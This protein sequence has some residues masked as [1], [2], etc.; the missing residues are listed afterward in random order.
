MKRNLI[1][2]AK[3][4]V[5]AAILYWLARSFPKENW[6]ALRDQ[7][8]HWGLLS[9]ALVTVTAANVVSFLRWRLLVKALGVPFSAIEAIRLG[10]LGCLFNLISAGS[11]GGDLFK[12][13]AA[14]RQAETKRPE[15][16]GSVV[17]DRAMGL[18]GLVLVAA[19]SLQFLGSGP[20]SQQMDWIRR[21]AW[22][23]SVI[24]LVT[25]ATVVIAGRF[26]PLH[27]L[28]QIPFMGRPL[29][30][31]AQAGLIMGYMSLLL[32]VA[33]LCILGTVIFSALFSVL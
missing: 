12:A 24:G 29:Y 6:E 17:V 1:A 7:P 11:V 33:L 16:I 30:R 25:L 9:I 23:L 21:G 26:L 18:L 13:I 10:F 28:N 19:V 4:I 15:V 2:I 31:M 22:L 32:I 27:W 5:L 14:A 3:L 8:K 20:L